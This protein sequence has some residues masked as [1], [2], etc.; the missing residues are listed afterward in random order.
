[1]RPALLRQPH[2]FEGFRPVRE[3]QPA[4]EPPVTERP[5]LGVGRLERHSAGLALAALAEPHH[6]MVARVDELLRLGGVL[7]PGPPVLAAETLDDLSPSTDGQTSGQ[8][9]VAPCVEF[10]APRR[11]G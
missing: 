2:G 5:H 3:Q 4:N 6:H 7:S 8:F 10:N 9:G 1:M 11:A